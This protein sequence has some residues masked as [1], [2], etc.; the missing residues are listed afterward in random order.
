MKLRRVMYKVSF[1]AGICHRGVGSGSDIDRLPARLACADEPEGY[2]SE[3]LFDVF[4][5][6]F[7]PFLERNAAIILRFRAVRR[8]RWQGNAHVRFIRRCVYQVVLLY[9]NETGWC[10]PMASRSPSIRPSPSRKAPR[11]LPCRAGSSRSTRLS[12]S[13]KGCWCRG[14]ADTPL[15]DRS[16]GSRAGCP[17][18]P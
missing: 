14:Y 13:T 5:D 15:R 16:P 8:V 18:R 10:S 11:Y 4:A 7:F 17:G 2:W 6:H 3:I 1:R 12:R 9:S